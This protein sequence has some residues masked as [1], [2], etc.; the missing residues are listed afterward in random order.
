MMVTGVQNR[1]TRSHLLL[2][3][4]AAKKSAKNKMAKIPT[5]GVKISSDGI[6]MESIRWMR[7]LLTRYLE[8][9]HLVIVGR[10]RSAVWALCSSPTVSVNVVQKFDHSIR[11]FL[12]WK[13][14]LRAIDCRHCGDQNRFQFVS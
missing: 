9:D 4:L 8:N 11:H 1:R 3:R 7:F 13:P 12:F 5:D 6:P 14:R 2:S 10:T